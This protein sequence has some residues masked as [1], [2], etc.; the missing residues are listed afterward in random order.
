MGLKSGCFLQK[1]K[2]VPGFLFAAFIFILVASSACFKTKQN[3]K[4]TS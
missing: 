4:Q 2:I 3:R 1:K